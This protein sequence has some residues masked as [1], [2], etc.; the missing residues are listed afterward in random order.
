MQITVIILIISPSAGQNSS[1]GPTFLDKIY[2]KSKIII[3]LPPAITVPI[4]LC[5]VRGIHGCGPWH[6]CVHPQCKDM[7]TPPHIPQGFLE[8]H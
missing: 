6:I 7:S 4:L 1:S 2:T 5:L 8:K 3:R